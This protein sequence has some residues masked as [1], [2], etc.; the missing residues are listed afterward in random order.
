MNDRAFAG[1]AGG[2]VGERLDG[3][4]VIPRV[5]AEP[6]TEPVHSSL[7]RQVLALQL[8]EEP[9]EDVRLP[10]EGVERCGVNVAQPLWRSDLGQAVAGA[11]ERRHAA[12][13][14]GHDLRPLANRRSLAHVAVEHL[15]YP[16]LVARR[17]ASLRLLRR[18]AATSARQRAGAHDDRHAG[19]AQPRLHAEPDTRKA[20]SDPRTDPSAYGPARLATGNSHH[21]R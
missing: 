4:L 21:E 15:A 2:R 7:P 3:A 9:A 19:P 17:G 10:E 12:A 18:A 8:V 16:L 1:S 11:L 13:Q 14:L 6:A 20:V 5:S